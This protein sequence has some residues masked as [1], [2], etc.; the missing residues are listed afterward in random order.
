MQLGFP[1]AAEQFLSSIANTI[2]F[3]KHIKD[4]SSRYSL[5]IVEEG[6]PLD[7]DSIMTYLALGNQVLLD[8]P[9]HEFLDRIRKEPASICHQ[10]SILQKYYRFVEITPL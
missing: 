4:E 8:A 5:M 1:V 9:S 6:D 7:L 10:T 3:A 2:D